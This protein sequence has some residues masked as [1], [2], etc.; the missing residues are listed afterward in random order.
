LEQ[1]YL[2]DYATGSPGGSLRIWFAVK[3]E[4]REQTTFLLEVENRAIEAVFRRLKEDASHR[5]SGGTS[6]GAALQPGNSRQTIG[7]GR[8]AGLSRR[9]PN[10]ADAKNRCRVERRYGERNDCPHA[11]FALAASAGC[12]VTSASRA[13]SV[14][15]VRSKGPAS[16]NL[17]PE[18]DGGNVTLV[19]HRGRAALA[20]SPPRPIIDLHP[21]SCKKKHR[22]SGREELLRVVCLVGLAIGGCCCGLVEW[23]SVG[24]PV[25]AAARLR[26]GGIVNLTDP[27]RLF[28]APACALGC[29]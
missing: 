19:S 29:S 26:P 20:T 9:Y 3:A 8:R 27:G 28:A 1:I 12:G 17:R 14:R 7:A 2:D 21:L 25:S 24:T 16:V 6:G 5:A 11:G 22:R 10:R 23:V 4:P 18:P 15:L 13:L